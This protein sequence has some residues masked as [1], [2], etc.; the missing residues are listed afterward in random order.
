MPNTKEFFC[1]L[2]LTKHIVKYIPTLPPK[3]ANKN[4]VFSLT[5][6]LP[7]IA[8]ILSITVIKIEIKLMIT[9]YNNICSKIC[10][11]KQSNFMLLFVLNYNII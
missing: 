1:V 7:Q 3:N 6:Y 2:C 10:H 9:K 4:K 11:P 5:R 8:K